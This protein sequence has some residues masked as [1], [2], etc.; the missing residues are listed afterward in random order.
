VSWGVKQRPPDLG[1]SPPL[2][3]L[4]RSHLPNSAQT[5]LHAL[6]HAE[7]Q[8]EQEQ[9]QPAS[10]LALDVQTKQNLYKS[11]VRDAMAAGGCCAS[12]ACFAGACLGAWLGPE[13]VPQAWA[14]KCAAWPEVK[15]QAE[16]VCAA[17]AT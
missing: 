9:Q 5:P 1:R 8:L 16:D 3:C 6:L 11:A 13:A 2:A 4:C 15:R 14:A 7:W 12:R 10:G 17:R